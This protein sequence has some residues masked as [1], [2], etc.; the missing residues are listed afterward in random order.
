MDIGTQSEVILRAAGYET[1]AWTGSIPP[2]TCFENESIVGFIHVFGTAEALL[3]D[4]SAAQQRTLARHATS[5]RAAGNKAWNV[6]SIL[7]TSEFSPRL[8]PAVERLEEDFSLTR[9][10]ARTGIQSVDDLTIV[11]LPLLPI[12]SQPLLDS[13]MVADRL[14]TTAKEVPQLALEAFLSG[15]RPEDVVDIL[16]AK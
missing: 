15:V 14:H 8:Q 2:V 10:I 7:L 13:A 4:W 3:K 1:W 9:K 11:L 12:K 6:Y 16:G 5:L